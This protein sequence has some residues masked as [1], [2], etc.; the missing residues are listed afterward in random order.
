MTDDEALDRVKSS[1]MIPAS[2]FAG[3]GV[4]TLHRQRAT[5]APVRPKNL[6]IA[7]EESL[8]AE[9]V[10]A[11]G[12]LPLTPNL[13]RLSNEGWWFSTPT[14]NSAPSAGSQRR[15]MMVSAFARHSRSA[16]SGSSTAT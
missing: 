2:D 16:R 9:L 5:V 3:E 15:S 10:G 7:V 6:V 13:D 14:D 11:L 8:G 12:G 1:M 4:P